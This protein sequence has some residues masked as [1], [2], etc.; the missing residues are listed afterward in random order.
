MKTFDDTSVTL[1]YYNATQ[2]IN[3]TWMWNPAFDGSQ[4]G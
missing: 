4:R 2:N 1:G 3:M